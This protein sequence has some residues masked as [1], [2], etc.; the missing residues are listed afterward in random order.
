MGL[1]GVLL[2]I[3]VLSSG[4]L[5]PKINQIQVIGT[6]NSYHK[7]SEYISRF[8]DRFNAFEMLYYELPPIRAQ[9]DVGIRCFELDLHYHIKHGWLVLHVPKLDEESHCRLLLDCLHE[10]RRWSN[11][12]PNHLPI[13]IILD[14]TNEYINWEGYR[15]PGVS[16]LK[17]LETVILE[18]VGIEKI[19][20]PDSVRG[21][22]PTLEDAVLNNNWISLSEAR[23]KFLFI[24]HNKGRL[25]RT[26]TGED[27]SLRGKLMFVNSLPGE[28]YSATIISV[29]PS[30]EEISSWVR[31][32]YFVITFGC[33]P[34]LVSCDI[35]PKIDD[36]AFASGAQV[37]MTDYPPESPHPQTGYYL[38]FPKGETFRWNPLNCLN[39]EKLLGE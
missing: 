39:C 38:A 32:G 9:L 19:V 30:N 17:E 11:E 15:L 16:E 24:F 37:V 18:S 21:D 36:K 29:N 20:T 35:C 22:F 27:K 25:R 23:G 10:F 14:L 12:N 31:R 5:E 26:Y 13:W 33:D 28:G 34:K 7:I 1:S 3:L 6:H 2:S 4:N 8:K